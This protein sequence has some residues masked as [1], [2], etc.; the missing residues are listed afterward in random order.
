MDKSYSRNNSLQRNKYP[1]KFANKNGVKKGTIEGLDF[2]K[3]LFGIWL[4]NKP[5]D[6]DLKDGMLGK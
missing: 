5:A 4:G 1:I 2:K 3:A 6:D